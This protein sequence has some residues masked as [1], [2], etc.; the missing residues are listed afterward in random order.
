MPPITPVR[1]GNLGGNCT[2]THV[3]FIFKMQSLTPGPI[4]VQFMWLNSS[5]VCFILNY[6]E[7]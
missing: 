7:L 4:G 5:S 2:N 1:T 6:N 3:K